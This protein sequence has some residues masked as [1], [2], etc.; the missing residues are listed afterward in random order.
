MSVLNSLEDV[1]QFTHEHYIRIGMLTPG[2]SHTD[3]EAINF[4]WSLGNYLH[5]FG[6]RNEASLRSITPQTL[7][8]DEVENTNLVSSFNSKANINVLGDLVNLLKQVFH[9]HQQFMTIATDTVALSLI[10]EAPACNDTTTG[11]YSSVPAEKTRINNITIPL[12][13]KSIDN[14]SWLEE[15]EETLVTHSLGNYLDSKLKH[16]TNNTL[17]HALVVKLL[18]A[19]DDSNYSYL[20]QH[21][22]KVK[23]F[24][25]VWT[26]VQT[27]FTD[28]AAIY[29]ET[30]K[31]W[32]KI[33]QNSATPLITFFNTT[34][35]LS[36][37]RLSWK[38]RS[39]RLLKM[40]PF[41]VP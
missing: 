28:K 27:T 18:N 20:K 11:G 39:Q 8:A 17:S 16:E 34:T 31:F 3:V 38:R 19:L 15:V 12:L 36:L 1:I 29:T 10:L 5:F 37:T 4:T 33:F 21:K 14:K 41:F 24:C 25:D 2:L 7:H 23:D 6:V 30:T 40:I 32:D 26:I 9:C 13:V 35:S 22:R